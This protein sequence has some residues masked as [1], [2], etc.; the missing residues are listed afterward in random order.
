M[1]AGKL[2]LGL[3]GDKPSGPKPKGGRASEARSAAARA[4]LAAIKAEDAEALSEALGL[5]GSC[6]DDVEE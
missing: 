1:S 4:L 5:H 6:K 2:I 3:L